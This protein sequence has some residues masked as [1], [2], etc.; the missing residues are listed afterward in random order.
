M[1][2]VAAHGSP[3]GIRDPQSSKIGPLG[4]AEAISRDPAWGGRPIALYA[5]NTGRGE[6]PFAQLLADALGVLV[7]APDNFGWLPPLSNPIRVRVAPPVGGECC[8]KDV[9]SDC[10]SDVMDEIGERP[11][12]DLGNPGRWRVFIPRQHQIG[13]GNQ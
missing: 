2:S 12:P 5:C 6:D 7:L 8:E 9:D 1:Y 3:T 4:L 11:R 13:Q 10:C